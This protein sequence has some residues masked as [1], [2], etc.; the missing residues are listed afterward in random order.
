MVYWYGLTKTGEKVRAADE[1]VKRFASSHNPMLLTTLWGDNITLEDGTRL[2]RTKLAALE[3]GWND[4][5]IAP[6]DVKSEESNA[7]PE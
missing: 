5:A 2:A 6:F 1:Q 4:I 7:K 3:K